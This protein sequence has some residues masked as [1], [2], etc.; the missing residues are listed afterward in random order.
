M[1]HDLDST[2]LTILNDADTPL[3]L[4]DADVS[5]ETL[6]RNFTTGQPT[7]DLFLFEVPEA[8]GMCCSS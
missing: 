3:E 4:H 8:S 2:L 5:F 6:D 7:V 1:F